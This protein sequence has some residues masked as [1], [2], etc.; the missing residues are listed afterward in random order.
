MHNMHNTFHKYMKMVYNGPKHGV[1]EYIVHIVHKIV[2]A[3]YAL[4]CWFFY[5]MFI[6]SFAM[7]EII[8][9]LIIRNHTRLTF[10]RSSRFRFCNDDAYPGKKDKFPPVGFDIV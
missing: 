10:T 2:L 3:I 4:E 6:I 1:A 8:L 7:K 9:E 5:I